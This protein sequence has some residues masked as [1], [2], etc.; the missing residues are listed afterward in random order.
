MRDKNPYFSPTLFEF[1]RKRLYLMP[2]WSGVMISGLK[3][4]RRRLSNNPVESY[5]HHL[6]INILRK[7]VKSTS[8]LSRALFT[9][10]K[11]LNIELFPNNANDQNLPKTSRNLVERFK[12]KRRNRN[13]GFY[14]KNLPNTDENGIALE[15]YEANCDNTEFNIAFPVN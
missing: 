1:I 15:D 7:K 11:A 6:K 9:N 14:F 12:T 3:I 5:F 13:K 4:H 10:L 2:M 8:E